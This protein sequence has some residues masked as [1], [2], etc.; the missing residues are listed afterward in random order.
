VTELSELQRRNVE[1]ARRGF[2]AYTN[3]DM[4]TVLELLDP[5]VEVE[6]VMGNMGTFRGRD[7]FLEWSVP[8]EETWEEFT[9]TAQE[10]VPV[11]D[12]HVVV[13]ADQHARGRDGIEVTMRPA[14]AYELGEDGL[15]SR[16]GL[17]FDF[18][19]ALAKVREWGAPEG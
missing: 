15:C 19:Q 9:S 12:R 10:I 8:W 2:D 17:Y 6:S 16:M 18:D 5:A 3:G 4:D 14:Y 13:Q 7:G 11:G 1:I